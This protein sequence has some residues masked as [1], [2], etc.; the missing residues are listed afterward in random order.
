MTGARAKIAS[1]GRFAR[2][3]RRIVIAVA[4]GPMGI[5]AGMARVD[6]HRSA[7]ACQQRDDAPEQERPADQPDSHCFIMAT[8]DEKSE[9]P[10]AR[11]AVF[12]RQPPSAKCRLAHSGQI[13][14]DTAAPWW[15]RYSST[16]A[17]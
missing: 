15:A 2:P 8:W 3:G 17:Q 9:G 5:R 12:G 6:A 1:L 10:A 11:A 4:F 7:A 14:C 13:P 16:D